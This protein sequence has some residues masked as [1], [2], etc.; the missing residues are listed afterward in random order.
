LHQLNMLPSFAGQE[1]WTFCEEKWEDKFLV[2]SDLDAAL[3]VDSYEACKETCDQDNR[4]T[5]AQFSHIGASKRCQK[6][7][8]YKDLSNISDAASDEHI[9]YVKGCGKLQLAELKTFDKCP[10]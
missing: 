2:G 3:A 9:L 6:K 5:L 10:F 1:E 4:C 8:G 7:R